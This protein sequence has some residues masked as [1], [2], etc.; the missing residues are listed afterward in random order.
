MTIPGVLYSLLAAVGVWAV[1]YFTVGPGNGLP[2]APILVAAVP[3]VL[4]SVST[5][6]IEPTTGT[7]RGIEERS[8]VSKW[9]LG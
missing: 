2:W 8:N 1:E 7:A 9:L 6:M 4:K 5:F 3:T